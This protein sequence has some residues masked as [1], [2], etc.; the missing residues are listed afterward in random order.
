MKTGMLLGAIDRLMERAQ[1]PDY[2]QM[3]AGAV[4]EKEIQE[5]AQANAQVKECQISR[6]LNLE[7]DKIYL[8]EHC[9]V[10]STQDNG[11]S[12]QNPSFD[13][14]LDENNQLPQVNE[15]EVYVP[16]CYRQQY[17][18]QVGDLMQI[19][20]QTYQKV[21][22]HGNRLCCGRRSS[23]NCSWKFSGRKNLRYGT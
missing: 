21:F 23:G 3:H 12:V 17:D 14:L 1:T 6:F 13:L 8:G 7:N 2:L 16:V 18:L 19:G 10:E 15:G 5:F 4:V 9:L 20:L 22:L 11:L